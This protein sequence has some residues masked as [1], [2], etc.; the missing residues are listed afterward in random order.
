[1]KQHSKGFSLDRM[2]NYYDL[3]TF[4]ERSK[5]R[6]K[7]IEL[8]GIRKGEKILEVGCGTGT[9][10]ILSKIAVDETGNVEGTDI[11]PGMISLAKQ[12]A[13]KAKLKID[14]K[15]ASINELPCP[16]NYFDLVISSLM[17]H[18]LPVEIKKEGLEEIYRV[19]KEDGRFF[20]CD[21]CSPH[22]LTI[23][24]MYFMFIWIPSTRFQ[25]LGKLPKLIKE[26]KFKNVEL[27]K[28]GA[29]LECYLI[30]KS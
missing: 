28:K 14:F 19:L 16:D 18:H 25:L 9:L 7:Q 20:L 27:I 11:A 30:T 2:S 17:F 8:M 3:L 5:F 13:E 10:S 4:T 22:I 1:M 12:K 6:R 15:V 21:F 29:L 26:C 24:L 23:P